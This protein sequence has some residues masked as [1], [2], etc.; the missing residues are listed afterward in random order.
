MSNLYPHTHPPNHTLTQP[1][2]VQAE[3]E[4]TIGDFRQLQEL[5]LGMAWPD[6]PYQILYSITSLEL[7]KIIFTTEDLYIW[8][9]RPW[10]D[11][12]LCKLVDRLRVAGYRHTL[13]VELRLTA[14]EDDCGGY[15]FT[16][17]FDLSEF[18][19]RGI[20]TII[21]AVHGDRLLH[22]SAHSH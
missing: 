20:V 18:R 5:D 13:E 10:I 9:T 22:S 1:S 11:R 2:R 15:D 19:E 14:I 3:D 4:V 7:Q 8:G 21:D 6:S 17:L 16:E 12:Q